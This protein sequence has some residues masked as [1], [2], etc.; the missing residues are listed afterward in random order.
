MIFS[1]NKQTKSK[2]FSKKTHTTRFILNLA[3]SIH[4]L[5]LKKVP[6]TTNNGVANV[7]FALEILPS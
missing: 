7:T 2:Y 4:S 5:R 6:E 3:M 1:N